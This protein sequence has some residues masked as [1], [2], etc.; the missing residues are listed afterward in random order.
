MEHHYCKYIE[1]LRR[2]TDAQ[3]ASRPSPSSD[4]AENTSAQQHYSV[5]NRDRAHVDLYTLAGKHMG[6]P[7]LKVGDAVTGGKGSLNWGIHADYIVV[8]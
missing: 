5:A 6:D 3:K 2:K 1:T 7:A 8:F 4:T